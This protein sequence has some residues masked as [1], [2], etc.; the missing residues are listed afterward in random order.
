MQG[1]N[2]KQ[3]KYKAKVQNKMIETHSATETATVK[4]KT[5]Q[6]AVF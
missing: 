1:K 2:A 3:G 6:V 4:I 5:I